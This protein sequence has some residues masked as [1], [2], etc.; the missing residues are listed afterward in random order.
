[1][2]TSASFSDDQVVRMVYREVMPG[3]RRKFVAQSNDTPSG[4][5]ARDF[6]YRPYGSFEGIFEKMLSNRKT[7]ARRRNGI[8]TNI[9]I[10]SSRVQ[11]IKGASTVIKEIEFEPPT[12]ARGD[13]GRLTRLS[14]YELEVTPESEG[15]TFLLL[16]QVGS[17]ELFLTFASEQSLHAELWDEN[18]TEILLDCLYAKCRGAKQGYHDFEMNTSFCKGTIQERDK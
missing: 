1:M 8:Q 14:H 2:V 15:R 12:D 18:I 3:D 16:Y 10:H 4:G 17:G 5:G 7:I 11:V 13:E 9:E 6:R